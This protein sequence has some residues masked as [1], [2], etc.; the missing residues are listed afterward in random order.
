MACGESMEGAWHLS[1]GTAH[2][3]G[4]L[5]ISAC[6]LH[7]FT[8]ECAALREY[9]AE[10]EFSTRGPSVNDQGMGKILENIGLAC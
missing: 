3:G 10:K 1:T 5:L 4:R 6:R 7:R 8:R 2:L 9:S